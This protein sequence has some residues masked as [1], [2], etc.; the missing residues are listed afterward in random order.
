VIFPPPLRAGDRIAVVAPSGSFERA[1]V[2]G[3]IAWLER[4][5]R[6]SH[7]SSLFAREG[8]LAGSDRRRVTEL[9]R[10]LDSED[11]RAIVAA[12]GG[13]GLSRIAHLLDF[14]AALARPRWLIGFSDFT[15]MHVEAW[16]R[17]LGSIHGAM[18]GALATLDDGGREQWMQTLE[19]PRKP[20]T[21][22]GLATWR[23]GRAKGTLVGGNL[24]MLHACAAAGRLVIPRNAVV[25]IEDVGERPYRVDR[26]LTNLITSGHLGRAA[27][28]L[29]GHF[30]ECGP[31]PDRRTV[32]QVLKERLLGLGVP[33]LAEMPVGHGG[34]NDAV[35]LG[36]RAEIDA[37]RGVLT[38]S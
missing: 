33:V 8:Y 4:R 35:V 6:V 20:A 19:R 31:G 36:G 37:V 22:R 3:G 17:G 7:R 25:L 14:T 29:V 13:Y 18:V 10:A 27:A 21:W 24:A 34:R 11:V 32:E 16:R 38:V 30:V 28:V 12:R 15:V 5:Y 26:M 1:A 9:Q 23:K 2:E